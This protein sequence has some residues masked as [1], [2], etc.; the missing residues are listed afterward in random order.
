MKLSGKVKN[1]LSSNLF[2]ILTFL[3]G[4]MVVFSTQVIAEEN[5]P[6]WS[7]GGANNPTQ[8]GEI[9]PNFALCELGKNQSPIN[10]NNAVEGTPIKIQF[11]YQ[12][13][14]LLVVNNGHT[15]QVNYQ[16]GSTMKLNDD[17]YEL[18]QFHFHTPSE[19]TINN[20]AS[21]LEMHL[22]HR[23]AKNQLAVV[24]VMINKGT[25]NP[26]I[27]QIWQH[28][29]T[30][31]KNNEVQNSTIN[32]ANLLPKNKAFFSYSGSL[33]TPP[34]SENVKWNLLIE[35]IQVSEK[36]IAAFQSLYQVNA[37][38]VQPVNSRMIKFHGQ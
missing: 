6:N 38:P 16:P 15:V 28:I 25:N 19:H 9:S 4:L 29:S 34:C 5:K 23:N 24:G 17:E 27:A 35:P 20:K 10:I 26:F 36:Q 1:I 14:P 37:R 18:I 3:I 7:Y 31:E 32:A 11:N 22:V 21:A 30:V 33:T 8:W 13:T 2:I 12:P